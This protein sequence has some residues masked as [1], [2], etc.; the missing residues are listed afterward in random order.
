MSVA[1]DII[2]SLESAIDFERRN[3][4]YS[5][6]YCLEEVEEF[7]GHN[8]IYEDA[9]GC[10]C[11]PA[12]LKTG[13]RGWLLCETDHYS[14]AVPHRLHTSVIKDVDYIIGAELGIVVRTENTILRFK[15][16]VE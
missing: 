7:N 14:G 13:E 10:I 1:E 9:K 4:M 3:N 5:K 2:K 8:P 11:Y 12:Y 16:V 15:E 6:K